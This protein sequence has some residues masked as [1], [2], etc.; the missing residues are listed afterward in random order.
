MAFAIADRVQETSTTTGTGTIVLSGAVTGYQT[1]AVIGDNNT[2]YYA[3]A[4]QVGANWEVGIGTYY[5]ANTSLSRTTILASSN[6]NTAVP[7]SAGSKSVF[8][9]YPAERA[10][11]ANSSNITTITNLVSSNVLAT[12]GTLDNV[13]IGATTATNASFTNL[14]LTNQLIANAS[15]GTSGQLLASAGANASPYWSTSPAFPTGTRLLFQQTAAP[16]G[17][18]KD[19]TYNNY[20][21]RITSGTVTTGGTVGFT[22]A[23]ASQAVSGTV[24]T[25]GSTTATGSV[26]ST[27]STTV[28]GSVG[29]TTLST[30][31][32]PNATGSMGLHGSGGGSSFWQPSGVYSTSTIDTTQYIPPGASS[33]GAS[34]VNGWNFN[35]QYGNGSH[36]HSFTGDAHTHT[37]G[38]F[39]GTAHTHTGGA[40]TGTAINLAVQY[41]DAIICSKD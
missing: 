34:S 31:Q 7:F 27:G 14:T 24:G 5:L 29:S 32:V 20:A 37:S 1:F 17:W 25:S 11:Y 22:T 28:S 36:N 10:I 12:G 8:V 19:T 2:T 3:I 40:F 15:S 23:F 4:D 38:A 16:T 21:L 26:A 30:S 41:V 9:T 6:A 18:T 33:G 13:I 39:T 35:A